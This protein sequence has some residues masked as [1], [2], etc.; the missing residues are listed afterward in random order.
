[1]HKTPSGK[2]TVTLSQ[3]NYHSNIREMDRFFSV[4]QELKKCSSPLD[5]KVFFHLDIGAEIVWRFHIIFNLYMTMPTTQRWK[6]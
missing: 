6:F 1:M 3:S 4:M 5:L 2:E